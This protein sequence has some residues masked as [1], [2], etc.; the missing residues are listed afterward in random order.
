[1]IACM[2]L[3]Q[4][5]CSATACGLS[6]QLHDAPHIALHGAW[7]V[8]CMTPVSVPELVLSNGMR[9]AIKSTNFLDDQILF[10]CV[11][12]VLKYTML[13][14]S[15]QPPVQPHLRVAYDH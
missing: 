11:D 9:L 5:L 2:Y 4:S 1:M 12:L 10:R 3:F 14:S 8:D 15:N 7:I 6:Y 13:L